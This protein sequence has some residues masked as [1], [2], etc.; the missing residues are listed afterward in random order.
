[1]VYT[2]CSSS[3]SGVRLSLGLAGSTAAKTSPRSSDE[4]LHSARTLSAPAM[5]LP[6]RSWCAAVSLQL[7]P[8]RPQMPIWT[9]LEIP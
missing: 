7:C 8:Q 9:P 6:A 3:K 1:M 5:L 2:W 4:S